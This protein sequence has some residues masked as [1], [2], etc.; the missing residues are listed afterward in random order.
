MDEEE[1]GYI[2]ETFGTR[3]ETTTEQEPMTRG[4]LEE[5]MEHIATTPYT[6]AWTTHAVPRPDPLRPQIRQEPFRPTW[7]D[8]ITPVEE[9]Q[10]RGHVEQ[11]L[12]QQTKRAYDI[13][14]QL[15]KS[16]ITLLYR[17]LIINTAQYK[18]IEDTLENSGN[19]R[20]LIYILDQINE[21]TF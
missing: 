20:E 6:P 2:S 14:M 16:I 13:E 1:Y 5:A 12:M 8:T 15:W 18:A 4:R 21:G 10:R 3:A 17:K 19:M 7:G 9:R 11:V